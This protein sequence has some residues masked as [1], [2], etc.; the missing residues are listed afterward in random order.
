MQTQTRSRHSQGWAS[1][2][3][4]LSKCWY[5]PN[6]NAGFTGGVI[7]EKTQRWVGGGGSVGK[8]W[9]WVYVGLKRP[10]N[11]FLPFLLAH[12]FCYLGL[13]SCTKLWV[14]LLVLGKCLVCLPFWFRGRAKRWIKQRMAF[15]SARLHFCLLLLL[16]PHWWNS[17][18][19]PQGESALQAHLTPGPC[20]EVTGIGICAA[21]GPSTGERAAWQ[22]NGKQHI[23]C[24]INAK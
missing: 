23:Y 19:C 24:T 4:D 12:H 7:K 18:P 20:S 10:T 11:S 3:F 9:V 22:Q 17:H 5:S 1:L 15:M 21:H 13:C 16:A 14:F 8:N 2:L 6:T